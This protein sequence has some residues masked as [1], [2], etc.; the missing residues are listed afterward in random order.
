MLGIVLD[1]GGT[2]KYL[3]VKE[4]RVWFVKQEKRFELYSVV[5]CCDKNKPRMLIQTGGDPRRLSGPINMH[6]LPFE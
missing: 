6:G 4:L 5:K 1:F 3:S 2:K